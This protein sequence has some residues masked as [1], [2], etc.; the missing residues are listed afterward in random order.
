LFGAWRF[1]ES[2]LV[3][4]AT[5]RHSATAITT[6]RAYPGEPFV[7]AFT[8]DQPPPEGCAV[9]FTLEAQGADDFVYVQFRPGGRH[10]AVARRSHGAWTEVTDY[11]LPEEPCIAVPN[12][13]RGHR[14]ELVAEPGGYV[15]VSVD[16]YPMLRHALGA[17]HA[18]GSIGLM[19]E[20]C[21]V[22]PTESAQSEIRFRD[23]VITR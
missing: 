15:R 18:G 10:I 17:D 4:T 1:A 8:L 14:V 3:G 6:E 22:D 13:A 5:G 23:V 12:G 11:Q 2:A 20:R 16:G 7:I 21:D 19:L 9:G